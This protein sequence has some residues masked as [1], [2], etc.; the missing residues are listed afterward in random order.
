[1]RKRVIHINETNVALKVAKVSVRMQAPFILI[2]ELNWVVQA[3][4]TEW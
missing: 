4:N 2:T 1:M 3:R